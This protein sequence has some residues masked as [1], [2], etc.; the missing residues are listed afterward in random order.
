M[1][2]TPDAKLHASTRGAPNRSIIGPSSAVLRM[3]PSENMLA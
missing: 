3:P 2:T 1:K